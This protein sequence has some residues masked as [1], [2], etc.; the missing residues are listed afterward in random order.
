MP[1]FLEKDLLQEHRLDH[2][3][4]ESCCTDTGS[5]VVEDLFSHALVTKGVCLQATTHENE[6]A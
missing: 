3:P 1:H 6:W 4:E 5:N 2:P